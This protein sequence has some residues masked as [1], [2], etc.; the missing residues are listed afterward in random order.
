MRASLTIALLLIASAASA[1]VEVRVAPATVA[2]LENVWLGGGVPG[3]LEY[4]RLEIDK[5]GT[6]LLAVR[7][8]PSYP[9]RMYRVTGIHLAGYRITIKTEPA[10]ADAEAINLTGLATCGELKLT[11][12]YPSNP[13]WKPNVILEREA[14]VKGRI[15]AVEERTA[16]YKTRP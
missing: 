15:K 12:S 10:E 3:P 11:L 16:A 5:K 7:F 4:L 1:T 2:C 9:P 14:I 8:L 13:K 6:G